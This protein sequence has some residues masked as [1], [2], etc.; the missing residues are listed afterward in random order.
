[1]QSNLY[2]IALLLAIVI[3][4]SGGLCNIRLPERKNTIGTSASLSL[5]EA[6][7]AIGYRDSLFRSILR[8]SSANILGINEGLCP[9]MMAETIW[10]NNKQLIRRMEVLHN[11]RIRDEGG[12]M[13]PGC[14]GKVVLFM[15]TFARMFL[16]RKRLVTYIFLFADFWASST[17]YSDAYTVNLE[18]D[19][20]FKVF[21]DFV[22]LYISTFYRSWPSCIWAT[23]PADIFIKIYTLVYFYIKVMVLIIKSH[24]KYQSI[25]LIGL[26]HAEKASS[27]N[28]Y[29]LV[30]YRS[31]WREW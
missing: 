17:Y 12:S 6:S 1:M 27:G 11:T 18:L 2:S 30:H 3:N 4:V 7:V 16:A 20:N 13:Y 8:E 10:N 25:I 21:F 29:I 28:R 23:Y 31:Y 26:T 14:H 9:C 19:D 22:Y 24:N 5:F 15:Q